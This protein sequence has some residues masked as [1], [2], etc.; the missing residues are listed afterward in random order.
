MFGFNK[1]TG[2][3]TSSLFENDGGDV[4]VTTGWPFLQVGAF[5]DRNEGKKTVVILN[6]ASDNANYVLRGGEGDI[7]MTASIPSHS[8][9]TLVL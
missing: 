8:I 5:I 3:L 1:T 2:E 6:E 9:Q 4:C 7:L